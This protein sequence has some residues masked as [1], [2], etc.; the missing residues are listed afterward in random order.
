MKLF[1][2][3]STNV[4]PLIYTN[5]VRHVF[6]PSDGLLHYVPITAPCRKF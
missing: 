3:Y 4:P 2:V 5:G 6:S 1:D